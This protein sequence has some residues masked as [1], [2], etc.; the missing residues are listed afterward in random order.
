MAVVPSAWPTSFAEMNPVGCAVTGAAKLR[1]HNCLEKPRAVAVELFPV[2][3]KLPRAQRKNGAR[4]IANANPGQDEK[5]Q[6]VNDQLKVAQP[7]LIRPADPTIP[8]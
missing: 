1:V 4:Q 7:L 8:C 2:V 6:V 3:R 5:A